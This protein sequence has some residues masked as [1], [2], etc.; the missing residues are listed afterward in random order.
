MEKND[1]VKLALDTMHGVVGGNFSA[2]DANE[3]LRQA[4]IEMNGG[5]TKINAKTFRDHPELF[6]II[7]EI[8]PVKIEE[9][10]RGDESIFSLVDY[11]N[12][13]AGDETRFW[14]EDRS[15]LVVANIADGSTSVRRQRIDAGQ[16]VT[17]DAQLR[18]IKVYEEMSRLMAGRID[19]NTLMDR[20]SQAFTRQMRNDMLATLEGV[21]SSTI[22]LNETYVKGGTFDAA[23]LRELIDHVEAATGKT[24]TILG[25]K[26]GLGAIADSSANAVALT[27]SSAKE[28][29]YNLGYF[30]KFSAT[31]M[32]AMR[33]F[34]KVGTDTFGLNDKKILVVAGDDKPI[35]M[36]NKGE[37]LMIANDSLSN[38]DLTRE[39]LFAQAYGCG[40]AFAQRMGIY[41]MA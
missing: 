8:L 10:L 20:L 29:L 40:A 33:Q 15:E 27:S 12:E 5:S 30:G 2:N 24:A 19:F 25:T 16:Y 21:T 17:F 36:L 32:V 28:D 41:T 22:G 4:F 34:H 7:E 6:Q 23:V 18:A 38:A 31:P 1:I 26:A 39:Y 14:I 11:R 3:A 37:A 9:G 35:K 13:A